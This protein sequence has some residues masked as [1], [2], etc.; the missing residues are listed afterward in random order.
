M[1]EVFH[2]NR[3]TTVMNFFKTS[4]SRPINAEDQ[5]IE[6]EWKKELADIDAG[7]GGQIPEE[8]DLKTIQD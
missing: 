2:T 6:E 7:T 8:E 1:S 5:Q 3:L 4:D